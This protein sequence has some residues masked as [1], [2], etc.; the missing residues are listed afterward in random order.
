LTPELYQQTLELCGGSQS[1]IA[2]RARWVQLQAWRKVY[3]A[4]LHRATGRW[5]LGA[6]E[7]HVF[8]FSHVRRAVHGARAFAAYLAE[9]PVAFVVCP[10]RTE[11][12]AVSVDRGELPAFRF[13]CEDILV[14]TPDL[15]WTMAFTHEDSVGLGPYFCQREWV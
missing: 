4:G 6:H 10:E 7:W 2:E 14:W 11:L 9:K 3:A 15:A 13:Q 1:V 8:S 12:P 5:K